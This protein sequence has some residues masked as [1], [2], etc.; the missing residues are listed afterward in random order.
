MT[1]DDKNPNTLPS[2]AA[3]TLTDLI[4]IAPDGI[5]SRIL[6]K[7]SGGTVT[8]F[9]FDESQFLSE[10]SAPFDALVQVIDGRLDLTIGEAKV[11]VEPGQIVLMPADIPHA[12]HAA[13]P[14]RMLLTMLK[15]IGD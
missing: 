11:T 9:A 5:V 2:D 14:S 15:Q 1:K 7:S 10:H 6:G 12:L 3:S 8:L 4:A 13:E